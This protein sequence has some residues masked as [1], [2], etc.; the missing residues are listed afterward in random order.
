MHLHFE[1]GDPDAARQVL[2][3]ALERRPRDR[4]SLLLIFARMQGPGGLRRPSR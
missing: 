1:R 3:E 2:E 4:E